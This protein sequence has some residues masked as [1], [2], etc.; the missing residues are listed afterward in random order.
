[1]C[2]EEKWKLWK[3]KEKTFKKVNNTG[4]TYGKA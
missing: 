4:I 1:M 3:K 2:Y